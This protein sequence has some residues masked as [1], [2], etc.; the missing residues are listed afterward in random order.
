M[1]AKLLITVPALA[2]LALLGACA[3]VTP[4]AAPADG[5][6]P[7]LERLVQMGARRDQIVDAGEYFV[8]EG[9]IRVEKKDLRAAGN[10]WGPSLQRS[11]P[12]P[13]YQ[14]TVLVDLSPMQAQDPSWADAARTAMASWSAIDGSS[15][16]FVEV[17]PGSPAHISVRFSSTLHQCSAGE[18]YYPVNGGPGPLVEISWQNRNA[19]N[20][21]QKVWVMAH[22]LGH[23]IG[24][25]HTDESFG[26]LIPGTPSSDPYSVMNSG[27]TY[28]GCPPAAPNWSSF[29]HYDNVAMWQLYPLP[30]ITGLT[31]SNVGGNVF[32]SWNAAAGASYYEYQK[33]EVTYTV[34]GSNSMGF[35]YQ[36]V[37]TNSHDTES[38]YSGVSEC[39]NSPDD[40]YFQTYFDW[41]VR[42]VFSN[43]K[44]SRWNSTPSKDAVC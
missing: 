37:Y 31:T 6:D 8:V 29:S 43:G 33:A 32:L 14:T 35:G 42:A 4:V 30:G 11:H 38:W 13:Q 17:S 24:L 7:L 41:Q 15:L 36:P 5:P 12:S 22:E 18:G 3:D 10:P 23:T 39:T 21:A 1:K 25:T 44:R 40:D 16:V 9:D 26:N 2:G 28:G 34:N 19:Y 27:N 20:S